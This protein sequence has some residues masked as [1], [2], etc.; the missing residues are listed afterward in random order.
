MFT[1]TE[2]GFYCLAPIGGGDHCARPKDHI[3][4]C[5]R[6]LHVYDAVAF[7]DVREGEVLEDV[8]DRIIIEVNDDRLSI[9]AANVVLAALDMKEVKS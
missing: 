7:Q 4:G 1:E 3:D 6:D 5:G 8:R 2:R 9:D